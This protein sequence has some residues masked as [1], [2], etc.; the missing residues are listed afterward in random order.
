MRKRGPPAGPSGQPTGS[1]PAVRAGPLVALPS[2]LSGFGVEPAP[3][4]IRAGLDPGALGNPENWIPADQL[5]VLIDACVEATNCEHF[6][7]LVGAPFTLGSMGALGYLMR[8]SATLIDALRVLVVHLEL[9]DRAAVTLMLDPSGSQLALGYTLVDPGIAGR[10]A[11]LDGALAMIYRLLT[12]LCGPAWRPLSVKLARPRPRLISEYE[13][14]FGCRPAFNAKVS[15]VVF[16]SRWLRHPIEGADPAL[17]AILSRTVELIEASK[18]LPFAERVRRAVRAM[19]LTSVVSSAGVAAL[20]G[21]NER[22]LRRRLEAEGTSVRRLVDDER[23]HLALN[24]LSNT[25]LRI[26]EISSALH[27]SDPVSFARAFRNSAGMSP[28]QWRRRFG[29]APVNDERS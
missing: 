4:M 22:T 1:T 17:H 3:L 24:L 14:V 18:P 25:R 11:I 10:Y 29:Q 28:R 27:Y 9:Q 16:E 13:R 23:R 2:L 21:L 20:F 26:S 19:I 7:L 6:G 15:A 8:H 12:E 5:G